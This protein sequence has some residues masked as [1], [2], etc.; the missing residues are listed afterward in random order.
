M[1]RRN[2]KNKTANLIFLI[3]NVLL[4]LKLTQLMYMLGAFTRAGGIIEP[5]A[6]G[7][8]T[9]TNFGNWI[10]TFSEILLVIQ[11]LLLIL[12]AFCAMKVG[13]HLNN[14]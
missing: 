9:I 11:A 10:S 6:P 5:S 12:L 13:R 3:A 1:L 14:K 2:F 8:E 7:N 4:V